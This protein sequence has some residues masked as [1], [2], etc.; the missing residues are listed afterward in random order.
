MADSMVSRKRMGQHIADDHPEEV[1]F[2]K[3]KEPA[4]LEPERATK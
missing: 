4:D 1:L 2:E 3:G